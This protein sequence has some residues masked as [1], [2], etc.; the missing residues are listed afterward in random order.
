MNQKI[1]FIVSFT[2]FFSKLINKLYCNNN[3]H[4][5]VFYFYYDNVCII[6]FT[7]TANNNNVKP[8]RSSNYIKTSTRD[9]KNH[10]QQLNVLKNHK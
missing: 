4:I 9:L 8:S 10:K 3:G 7:V 6:T 2:I 5:F 1:L